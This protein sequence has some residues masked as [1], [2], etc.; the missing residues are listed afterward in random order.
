MRVSGAARGVPVGC[1]EVGRKEEG[2]FNV[3]VLIFKKKHLLHVT[4][5]VYLR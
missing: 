4:V 1:Y 5:S 2:L 3:L